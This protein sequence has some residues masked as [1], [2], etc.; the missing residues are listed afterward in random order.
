MV[1]VIHEYI[2]LLKETHEPVGP[3]LKMLHLHDWQVS[4]GCRQVHRI[5]CG[6]APSPFLP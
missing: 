6:C 3:T 2:F 1:L 4:V 5:K